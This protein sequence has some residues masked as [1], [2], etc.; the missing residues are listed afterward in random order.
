MSVTKIILT[1]I[2]WLLHSPRFVTRLVTV[3]TAR[4]VLARLSVPTSALEAPTGPRQ[5]LADVSVI[6]RG[7]AGTGIQRVVRE[8]LQQLIAHPPPGYVVRPVYAT[9]WH[10][11][12]HASQYHATLL[13]R[14][15]DSLAT[16][17]VDVRAG[18][19]FLGMDLAAR[20]LP[21]Y[22]LSLAR[23]KISGVKFFFLVYDLLPVLHPEW[24]TSSA[25][26][27]YRE[28]I[29]TVATFADGAVCISKS[30]SDELKQWLT[31]TYGKA[32]AES[33]SATWFHLS[34][35]IS[36]MKPGRNLSERNPAELLKRISR[37]PSILMVGT[38]EPRKGYE[39]VLAAFEALWRDGVD[40]NLVIVGR[41]GWKVDELIQKMRGHPEAGSRLIWFDDADDELLRDLYGTADGLLMASEG[42]G[43]GLPMAEA[44]LFRKPVLCRDL[45]VFRETAENQATFFSD[46]TGTG[47]A[48]SISS[49]LELIRK[50]QAPTMVSVGHLTWQDSA[51]DLTRNLLQHSASLPR[52]GKQR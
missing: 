35:A 11:F 48:A 37:R 10:G 18:D 8:L 47:L 42:E 43:F 24:F 2:R 32:V 17:A 28:W 50:R 41:P 12:R 27:A 38:I 39:Q 15:P 33:I 31:D 36:T 22:P 7:D 9:H 5:I 13:G 40:V 19:I 1:G 23:W 4:A 20:T 44:A 3:E 26:N 6:S 14:A 34:G 51:R 21:L 45:P 30:V 29:R 46:R 16:G 49:W 25:V 52:A